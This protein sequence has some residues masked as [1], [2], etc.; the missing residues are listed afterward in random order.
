MRI[1]V[2]V[3]GLMT[4]LATIGLQADEGQG[5]GR[6]HEPGDKVEVDPHGVLTGAEERQGR[7]SETARPSPEGGR[8]TPHTGGPEK[9]DNGK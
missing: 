2:L 9:T 3:L 5:A 6:A 4:M 8:S 1:R 7:P